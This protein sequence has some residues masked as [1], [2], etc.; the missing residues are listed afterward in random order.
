MKIGGFVKNSFVD[1]PGLISSVIFTVGCNF[2]CWYL[3]FLRFQGGN[4]IL[5]DINKENGNMD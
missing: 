5:F 3:I 4:Q 1:Y 2:R